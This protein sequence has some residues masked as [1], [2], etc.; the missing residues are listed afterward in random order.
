M[1]RWLESSSHPSREKILGTTRGSRVEIGGP[2]IA[3]GR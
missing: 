3:L 2:P 1:C